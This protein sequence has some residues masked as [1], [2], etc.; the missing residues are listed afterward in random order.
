[1]EQD[2][3]HV[4]T[5]TMTACASY[6]RV[7]WIY[8]VNDSNPNGQHNAQGSALNG[9]PLTQPIPA[10]GVEYDNMDLSLNWR[11]E[12]YIQF[13]GVGTGQVQVQYT[14]LKTGQP[15]DFTVLTPTVTPQV[16]R[17]DQCP[18]GLLPLGR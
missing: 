15:N 9:T 13:V 8:V 14:V 17:Q 3:S 7:A 4:L 16:S 12:L 2:R 5:T 6:T 11:A 18:A 1:M 10:S